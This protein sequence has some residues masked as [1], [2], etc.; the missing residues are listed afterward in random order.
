M[1]KYLVALLLVLFCATG[2]MAFQNKGMDNSSSR[3][4]MNV[5][6][7][8]QNVTAEMKTK[9]TEINKLREE[10]RVE[11]AKSSPNKTK[12]RD[13]H[14]K[15]RKTQSELS[16]ARFE[17]IL[18]NPSEFVTGRNRKSN[19]SAVGK[20]KI[21]QLRKLRE[22]MIVEFKKEKP[23]KTKLRTLQKKSNL[24]KTELADIRFENRL[25]NGPKG[26]LKS[27]RGRHKNKSNCNEF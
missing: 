24:L 11:L 17:E 20:A 26:D 8:M 21:D 9:V 15:I 3:P 1:K 7:N 19:I 6:R 27:N 10:L 22:E 23:D 2:A 16:D 4:R 5:N 12:A 18:K 13:I 14:N 25:K